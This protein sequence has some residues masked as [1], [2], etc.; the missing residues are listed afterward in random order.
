MCGDRK[1]LLSEVFYARWP[2]G[3]MPVIAPFGAMKQ[4]GSP[5]AA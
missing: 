4:D 2:T 1:P 5:L 3:D